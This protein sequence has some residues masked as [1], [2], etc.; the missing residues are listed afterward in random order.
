[1]EQYITFKQAFSYCATQPT[2]WIWVGISMFIFLLGFTA[3]KRKRGDWEWSDSVI[4]FLLFGLLLTS[5]IYRPLE[6]KAN[7][8]IEQALRDS[9]IGF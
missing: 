1:M 7:T 6:V 4:L 3:L 2:Y 5:I 8:T 9:Y